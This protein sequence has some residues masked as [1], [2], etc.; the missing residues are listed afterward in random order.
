MKNM[1]KFF[2]HSEMKISFLVISCDLREDAG[3]VD[4]F[5]RNGAGIG[6]SCEAII[7]LAVSD[8]LIL[9]KADKFVLIHIERII[10]PFSIL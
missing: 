6:Y 3:V 4:E 7:A 2:I 10:Y 9:N 5:T 8:D 1:I